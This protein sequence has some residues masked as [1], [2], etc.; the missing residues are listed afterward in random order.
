MCLVLQGAW[1][2]QAAFAVDI[3]DPN[4]LVSLF[5][6][7]AYLI[8]EAFLAR[9]IAEGSAQSRP[10]LR[11]VG[12]INRMRHVFGQDQQVRDHGR[13]IGN[14]H[15]PRKF[16]IQCLAGLLGQPFG[17]VLGVVVCRG[18]DEKQEQQRNRDA[19]EAFGDIQAGDRYRL[20]AV[21]HGGKVVQAMGYR[22]VPSYP[23]WR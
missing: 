17:S 12:S 4:H 20:C 3:V 18:N 6:Q 19:Q 14:D 10:L 1:R 5:V 23:E 16:H 2:D 8:V 7:V 9:E 22:V 13:D 15:S 21:R 11:P